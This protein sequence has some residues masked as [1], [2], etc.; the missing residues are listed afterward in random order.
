MTNA[1]KKEYARLLFLKENMTQQEIAQRV[2]CTEATLS[3]W[4]TKE[5]W[6]TMKKS[7]L[8]TRQE[9][10]ARLYDQ[11]KELNDYILT[12]QEGQ[13]FANSKEADVI[14]KLTASIRELETDISIAQVVD[15][16][17][18]FNEFMRK[19]DIDKAKEMIELQDSFIKSLMR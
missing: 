11:L 5:G 14:R 17:I 13:R 19:I 10:L 12:K 6:D 7:L 1:Q 3:G 8:A 15:V 18:P 9:E 2:G 4:K 16:M